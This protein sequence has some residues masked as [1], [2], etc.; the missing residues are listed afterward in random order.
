M[1]V[2]ILTC[3]EPPGFSVLKFESWVRP[4][5]PLPLCRDTMQFHILE[6]REMRPV[7]AKQHALY[8]TLTELGL[9]PAALEGNQR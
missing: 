1:T 5:S 2:F 6:I 7:V 9:G 3:E 4:S 8:I